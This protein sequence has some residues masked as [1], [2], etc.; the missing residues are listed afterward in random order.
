[1]TTT[2]DIPDEERDIHSILSGML[3]ADPADVDTLIEDTA[4]RIQAAY[5]DGRQPTNVIAALARVEAEIGGIRKMTSTER[6]RAGMHVDSDR[7]VKWAY[8]GI[9]QIAQAAQPLF[10]RY[11][12]VIVPKVKRHVVDEIMVNGNPWTDTTV[13][14]KWTIYGPGGIQ[15]RITA[16]TVGLGRDNSDKGYNKAMTVAYK[17]LLLRLLSIGDPKDDIDHTLEGGRDAHSYL[18][19]EQRQQ[20]IDFVKELPEPHKEQAKVEI[21]ETW[22]STAKILADQWE[23]V[24]AFMEKYQALAVQD[25]TEGPSHD[26]HEDEQ[27]PDEPGPSEDH[28]DGP[29]RISQEQ[30]D[31]LEVLFAEFGAGR[32]PQ[33]ER[34]FAAEFFGP[35]EELPADHFDAACDWLGGK[36]AAEGGASTE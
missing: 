19:T 18:A 14:V 21:A 22:E 9:D 16:Y 32:R 35:F 20:L 10:G 13:E 36:L 15:D 28:T 29:E 8:R 25:A 33:V 24:L 1:M 6:Q 7:G 23:A 30:V 11:G 31:A 2:Y 5:A 26:I 12:V 4:A 34:E 17:N 27:P 3:D